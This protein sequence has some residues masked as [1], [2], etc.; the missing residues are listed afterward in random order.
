MVIEKKDKI[1]LVNSPIYNLS[2]CSLE[3][4]HTC[5]LKWLGQNYPQEFLKFLLNKECP[6][7]LKLNF[8]T[9]VRCS[10][11]VILDLQIKIIDGDNTEYIVIENKL[12]SYPTNEQL[13]KYQDCIK[14]R[15][16]TF[17]LLSLASKFELPAGWKY[18]SYQS[19]AETL[20][21]ITDF[22]NK[23]DEFL[24]KD[25]VNV[26]TAFSN[27]F[28]KISTGIYD[29]YELNELDEIGL[30]DIYVKYRTTE[31]VNYIEKK[32][33]RNDISVGYS[34]HNKKGTIDIVK[35]LNLS[36]CNI[37][38]Q[39]EGN[40]YRYF[41]NI[42]DV[43]NDLR[44]EIALKISEQNYWFNNT[45]NPFRPK[46]YNKFCGYEPA[47]I[48]R[49]YEKDL[50]NVSYEKIVE[51]IE[52][53]INILDENQYKIMR[54]IVDLCLEEKNEFKAKMQAEIEEQHQAN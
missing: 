22:K 41:M 29:F 49:Y 45:K 2:M 47:F 54:I 26:V 34:F 53:D 24:I 39:I 19:L 4:F 51:Q 27:A 28:P 50:N 35:P 17:I 12:K 44:E 37:G 31:F 36:G 32:L 7:N 23:Y 20:S 21:K 1:D 3:N 9:Q 16:A 11:D 42:P 6:D 15:N 18:I 33:N 8:E 30:K 38:I 43:E 40:Q 13:I 48:Y 5:F 10:K 52:K 25:Y 46:I 14:D